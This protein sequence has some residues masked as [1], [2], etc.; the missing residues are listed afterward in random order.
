[1]RVLLVNDLPPGPGSGAEVYLDRLIRGLEAE[2]D[3]VEVFAGEVVHEGVGK[4]LDV[5]DPWA[6]RALHRAV[7]TFCPD[8]V[9]HHNVIRELSVSV[10]RTPPGVASVMTAHD[11]RLLG[12]PDRREPGPVRLAKAAKGALD[13]AVIRRS[14]HG[15]MAVS[16]GLADELRRAGFPHVRHVPTFMPRSENPPSRPSDSRDVVFV[17]R[18]APDKGTLLL[19]EAF[20]RLDRR[21]LEARLV[22]IGEGPDRPALEDYA[23]RLPGRIEI[24]GRLDEAGVRSALETARLVALPS[25]G[26]PE[27][28][29]LASLE[30]A[31]AA[32]PLVVS[33]DPGL[34]EFV[35][36]S[37]GGLV[38]PRGD[39][40]ALA[41]ALDE[42]LSHPERADESG[43]RARAYVLEHRTTERVVPEIR[44][45]YAAAVERARGR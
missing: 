29:P 2:G 12:A 44:R 27:G 40:D 41:A 8:V 4:V 18:L 7:G 20:T 14:V 26:R 35:H 43:M 34:R 10:V 37:G 17:G 15:L 9:H 32:R 25:Q 39:V 5:W 31:L 3:E 36:Q 21:H 28:S 22:C 1:M 23:A 16:E 13:R 19:A 38:V 24:R 45:V 33:D 42:L 11:F 30:A 6:R